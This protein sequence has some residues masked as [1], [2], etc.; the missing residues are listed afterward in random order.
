[1]STRVT[2][3]AHLWHGRAQAAEL[4]ERNIVQG[5]MASEGEKH[6]TERQ[7]HPASPSQVPRALSAARL[8]K[9]LRPPF[10]DLPRRFSW[11]QSTIN[12]PITIACRLG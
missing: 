11:N 7:A 5:S 12:K 6:G 9:V 4:S 10:V 3:M 8:S 1:M 2:R